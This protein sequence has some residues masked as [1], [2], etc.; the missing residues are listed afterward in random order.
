MAG[1]DYLLG[2]YLLVYDELIETVQ[3]SGPHHTSNLTNQL[4]LDRGERELPYLDLLCYLLTY[5]LQSSKN[6]V[7]IY[8]CA[9][10][11]LVTTV[12]SQ[13]LLLSLLS[14]L[15]KAISHGKRVKNRLLQFRVLHGLVEV[16][17]EMYI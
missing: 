8:T 6:D 11:T 9:E 15:L 5:F 10:Y 17:A 3:I 4:Q 12:L 13:L 7:L 2:G 16:I 1:D 14:L